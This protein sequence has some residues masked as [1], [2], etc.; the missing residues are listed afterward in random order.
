MINDIENAIKY[1][2][3]T[4]RLEDVELTEEEIETIRKLLLGE[5]TLEE[6]IESMINDDVEG[7]EK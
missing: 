7:K 3:D 2:R 6:V 1:A 5:I 4:Q